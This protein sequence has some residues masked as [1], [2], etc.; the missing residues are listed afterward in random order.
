VRRAGVLGDVRERLGDDEVRGALDRL[1]QAVLRFGLE[2]HRQRPTRDQP[3]KRR[4]EPVLGQ[5]RGMDPARQ[6][7]Q[8]GKAR[9]EFRLRALQQP[10]ELAIGV[11]AVARRAQEQRET[12]EAGLRAVVEVALESSAGGVARLNDPDAGRPQLL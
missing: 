10:A 4:R 2:R 12:D 9:L 8:L 6:L 5:D 7:A 11:R 1:G 3:V